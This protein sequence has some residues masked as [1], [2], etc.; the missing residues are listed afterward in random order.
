MKLFSKVRE[1]FSS[2]KIDTKP[3]LIDAAWKHVEAIGSNGD[4]YE[5]MDRS[6]DVALIATN[7]VTRDGHQYRLEIHIQAHKVR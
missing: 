2:S 3:A 1:W 5:H 4:V 6:N 7:N